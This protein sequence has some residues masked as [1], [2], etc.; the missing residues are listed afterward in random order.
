[1]RIT[2][3]RKWRWVLAAGACLVVV[4]VGLGFADSLSWRLRPKIGDL[5][6]WKGR[7][8]TGSRGV[9]CGRVK[10]GNDATSATQCALKADADGKPFRVTYEIQGYDAIVAGG[11]VRRPDG[12]VFALSYDSCPSGCGFDLFEQSVKVTPCP[13][14]YHLYVNPKSRINCF[15]PQLS[16]P[17]S[18]MSPNSEPY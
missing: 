2:V 8:L 13:Q 5:M 10:V 14:P 1:M 16:Y 18:L 3:T 15:R 12:R 4:W 17:E 11:I 7:Y 9:N 6:D